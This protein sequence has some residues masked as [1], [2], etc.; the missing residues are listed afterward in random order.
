LPPKASVR[1]VLR[2]Y[3]ESLL[4]A[5]VVALILRF[6]VLAAYKIPTTSMT[7]TLKSGD[8][9][10]AYKL[11]YGVSVP[12]SDVRLASSL[13]RRGDVVVFRLPSNETTHFIKRVVALPGEKVEIRNRKLYVNDTVAEYR[14]APTELIGDLP[15]R[16]LYAVLQE[17]VLGSTHFVMN[18][19]EEEAESFGPII[20]P[21]GQVFVLGDNR[22]SSDDSR[23]WGTVPLQ[24]LEGQIVVVWLSLDW[25]QR[26]GGE[27]YP[28]IRWERFFQSVR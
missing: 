25:F 22:D 11:S 17:S 3:I 1:V 26:W 24:N 12:F 13:P 9:V 10:F 4:V 6:F 23:Y 21:P 20:V 8:F 14:E 16:E 15:G 28:S 5:I 2:E 27:R 7:P 18:R 19:N